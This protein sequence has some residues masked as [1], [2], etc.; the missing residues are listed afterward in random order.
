MIVFTH[1][2]SL[3]ALISDA[4][5]KQKQIATQIGED[6]SPSMEVAIVRTIG[7]K[8]GVVT[9]SLI[10][11]K[12]V[13][14]ALNT[15]FERAKMLQNVDP[16]KNYEGYVNDMTSVCSDFRTLIERTVEE[17]L[18]NNIVGRFRRSIITQGRLQKLSMINSHDAELIDD[19]MT[20]YSV[21][22]HSQSMELPSD[23]PGAD[24][25]AKDIEALRNWIKEF[26]ARGKNT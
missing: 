8:V 7:G 18:L 14:P 21:Y 6:P 5:K 1:R 24:D 17:E 23:P 22:E 3:K 4:V 11:E 12:N 19:L 25:V 13:V 10:S 9:D 2:L 15:V 20:R 26:R 16:A